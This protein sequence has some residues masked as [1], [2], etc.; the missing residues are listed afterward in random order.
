MLQSQKN[1]V[2]NVGNNDRWDTVEFKTLEDGI[3]AMGKPSIEW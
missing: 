3:R 1:N 2:G